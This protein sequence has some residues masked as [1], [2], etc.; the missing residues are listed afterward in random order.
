MP[1]VWMEYLYVMPLVFWEACS[2]VSSLPA[3][4]NAPRSSERNKGFEKNLQDGDEGL[5][6]GEIS[7]KRPDGLFPQT[8][9]TSVLNCPADFSQYES[10]SLPGLQKEKNKPFCRCPNYFFLQHIEDFP[11]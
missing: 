7:K 6:R 9:V 1:D 8:P 11:N 5:R 3:P 4:Q 2:Y 10:V